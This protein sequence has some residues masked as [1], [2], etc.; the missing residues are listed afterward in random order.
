MMFLFFFLIWSHAFA[1]S[2]LIPPRAL[3]VNYKPTYEEYNVSDRKHLPIVEIFKSD[4]TIK[5]PLFS[6]K[7]YDYQDSNLYNISQKYYEIELYHEYQYS[8]KRELI[9]KSDKIL[10]N[11]HF[12]NLNNIN[13]HHDFN[14]ILKKYKWEI[15]SYRIRSTYTENITTKWS[16]LGRFVITSAIN[17]DWNNASYIAQYTNSSFNIGAPQFTKTFSLNTH[18]TISSAIISIVGLGFFKLYINNNDILNLHTPPIYQIGGWTNTKFRVPYAVFDIA[19]YL[20]SDNMNEIIVY[21]GDGYRNQT[22]YSS[23]DGPRSKND[24]IDCILKL[25]LIIKYNDNTQDIIITNSSWK[26]S[27]TKIT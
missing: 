22:V 14:N 15:L 25:Q 1:T 17:T 12:C 9:W 11:K 6:W 23:N 26:T 18:K 20:L 27:S 10:S 4:L 7:L 3:E 2:Y 13:I 16:K 21:L 24:T 5:L 19:S 8:T